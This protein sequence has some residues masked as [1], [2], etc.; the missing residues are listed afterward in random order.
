MDV[1]AAVAE[2]SRRTL[3]DLLAEGELAAGALVAALPGLTQPAVSRHRRILRESG[4]VEVRP[5]GQRRI[6]ALRPEGL[7]RDRQVARPPPPPP[8]APAAGAAR[9]GRTSSRSWIGFRTVPGGRRS[10]SYGTHPL[11]GG[12]A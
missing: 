3:L 1:F 12:G 5:D 11:R 7:P 8:D 6:Y 4:L 10:L 9:K 2:P